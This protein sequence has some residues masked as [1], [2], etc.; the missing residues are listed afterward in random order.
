MLTFE[1]LTS[2]QNVPI[3]LILPSLCYHSH[4]CRPGFSVQKRLC[5]HRNSQ[6]GAQQPSH[7]FTMS[8]SRLRHPLASTPSSSCSHDDRC[9]YG[10][11]GKLRL[12]S[13]RKVDI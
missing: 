3:C 5:H 9:D 2:V 8:P 7:C 4:A 12:F 11:I 6:Y 1:T 13:R 10:I